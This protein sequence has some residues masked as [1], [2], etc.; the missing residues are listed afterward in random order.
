M[1]KKNRKKSGKVITVDFTDVETRELL[2]PD[3]YIAKVHDIE[4][5]EGDKGPYLNW[6]LKVSEGEYKGKTLYYITSLTKQS[7]WNLRAVL[8]ALGIE[9]PKSKLS[10]DL[11][12]YKGLEMGVTV[13]TEKYKNKEKNVVVDVYNPY[14]ED[15]GDSDDGDEDSNTEEGE[16]EE[17]F[18]GTIK[19]VEGDV[20]TVDIDD[21]EVEV[22]T[23]D[24][25]VTG[26]PKEGS[27]VTIKGSYDED[28][29]LIATEVEIKSSKSSK[30]KKSSKKG[31]SKK[32]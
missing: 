32:K 5:E 30:S 2:P 14:E 26:K 23:E 20:L 25:E 16:E 10:L 4:E 11:P 13:E 9:V 6:I 18:T 31:K 27:E 17:E 7:L 8:E 1:P 28:G 29:D 21:E 19:E 12:S 15:S 24:A 22:Y 3:E